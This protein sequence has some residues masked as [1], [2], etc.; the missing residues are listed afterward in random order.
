MKVKL[1]DWAAAH[2]SPPPSMW[3]LR[4][5]VRAGQIYPAPEKVGSAYYVDDTARR[6]LTP[7]PTVAQRMRAA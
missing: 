4:Q 5:W 3:T 2:Y 6:Q 1:S 7:R